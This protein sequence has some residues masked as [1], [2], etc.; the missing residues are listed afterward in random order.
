VKAHKK[1]PF[2][3]RRFGKRLRSLREDAG[4]SM[5]AAAEKLEF[6]RS[7]LFRLES[8]ESRAS[9]HVV[10]SM[11]DVYDRWEEGLL[12]QARAALKQGWWTAYGIK[13]LGYIDVETEASRVCEYPGMHLPGL[14]HTESYIRALFGHPHYH[15]SPEQVDNQVAVR[16][17]RQKRLNNEGDPLEL[18]AIVD[19]AALRREIGGPEVMHAQLRHMIE[20]A[21]LPTVTLQV[22]R[23]N[24]SPPSALGGS[25]ILLDFPEP[26]EPPMLYHE[27]VTG[28]LHIED[29]DEVRRARLVFDA[30]RSEAL[31]PAESVTLIDELATQRYVRS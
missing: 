10:R 16:L 19:E 1:P 8:G 5:D 23:M 9:V 29:D 6:S 31:N 3:R 28:A 2:L 22:L 27:Y 20:M 12:E 4:L 18:V 13:D 24:D 26:D 15:R 17:I 7:A 21:A 11:M 25:F 14:L 30:L